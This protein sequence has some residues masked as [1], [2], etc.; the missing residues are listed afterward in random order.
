MRESEL[1]PPVKAWHESLGCEVFAEVPWPA[2]CGSSI[3]VVGLRPRWK[4]PIVV[5]LKTGFTTKLI[6][7]CSLAQLITPMVWAAAPTRPGARF[8][9]NA[10]R[11]GFGVLR[12]SKSLVTILQRWR[13]RQG[14]PNRRTGSVV[15]GSATLPLS[16]VFSWLAC[17]L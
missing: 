4:Y 11:L 17:S 13:R 3:D 12:V 16:W 5:E 1:F 15:T 10:E 8:L 2:P 7:Q 14:C 6:E 9:Q